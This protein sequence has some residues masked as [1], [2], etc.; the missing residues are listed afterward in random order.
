MINFKRLWLSLVVGFGIGM[1]L[2]FFTSINPIVV[3]VV[4]IFSAFATF[5]ISGIK[6][7]N[8]SFKPPKLW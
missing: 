7:E 3:L 8:G 1:L 5:F 2:A 6:K 4:L